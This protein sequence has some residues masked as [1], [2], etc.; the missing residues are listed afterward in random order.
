MQPKK[1]K[2]TRAS[3]RSRMPPFNFLHQNKARPASN[4]GADALTSSKQQ[5]EKD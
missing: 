3:E 2:R 1:E 4:Y 5:E